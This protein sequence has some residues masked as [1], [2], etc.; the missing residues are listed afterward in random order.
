MEALG[1]NKMFAY[2]FTLIH[3]SALFIGA[4]IIWAAGQDVRTF[5]INT[6]PS[7]FPHTAHFSIE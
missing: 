7:N 2:N 5:K 6:T 3:V 1:I 4:T